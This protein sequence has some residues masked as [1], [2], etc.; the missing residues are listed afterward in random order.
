MDWKKAGIIVGAAAGVFL[1]VKYVL[2][3]MLPFFVGFLLSEAVHPVAYR[4]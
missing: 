3:V 2:P 1:G 4:L